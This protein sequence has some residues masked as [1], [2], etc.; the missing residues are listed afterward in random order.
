MFE[1]Y[2]RKVCKEKAAKNFWKENVAVVRSGGQNSQRRYLAYTVGWICAVKTE[3]VAA[4]ELLDEEYPPLPTV[5]SHD[6][7]VYTL[8][9]IGDH[10]VVVACHPNGRY[11]IASA[12]TVAKDML[13][14]FESVRIGLIVGIG[15]GA[16][17]QKNDI[18]LGD[19]VVGCPTMGRTRGVLPYNFDKAVHGESEITG[20]LKIPPPI[21]LA[22]LNR[23]E[24]LHERKGHRIAETVRTMAKNPRIRKRYQYPGQEKD[25][26]YE[27]SYGHINA[28]VN[29]DKE[30]VVHYG[31]IAS[32]HQL[33]NNAVIR[34]R[35]CQQ[36]EVA[37]FEMEAAGLS[38]A[39]PCV[40][41]RGICDYSDS[42]KDNEW[43]E[44]AAATAATY[45]RELLQNMSGNGMTEHIRVLDQVSK[46][47]LSRR[48]Y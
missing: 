20:S 34:D 3:Y 13:H 35:M 1:I 30:P 14:S 6:N 45:A 44:Y 19:V 4:C 21:L 17:S 31:I 24:M 46:A 38:D 9:R 2:K 39:I 28:S 8:G 10:H 29:C 36:H 15:G 11:G 37:C 43:H 42:H 22:T 41:I 23:L 33:M 16:P 5:S 18:R 25:R 27:S 7:N 48:L 47:V 32:A 40:V 12:A 26:W